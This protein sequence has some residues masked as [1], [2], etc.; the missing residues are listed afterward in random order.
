[1]SSAGPILATHHY[2]SIATSYLRSIIGSDRTY[3]IFTLRHRS[4]L[5]T[6]RSFRVRV[7]HIFHIRLQ[8]YFSSLAQCPPL[9]RGANRTVVSPRALVSNEIQIIGLALSK[10]AERRPRPRP[11]QTDEKTTMAQHLPNRVELL[12]DEPW[13]AAPFRLS[14]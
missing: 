3:C 11:R 5:S 10:D 8:Q 13:V 4:F 2:V 12:R 6:Y 14:W 9:K 7:P 1:M